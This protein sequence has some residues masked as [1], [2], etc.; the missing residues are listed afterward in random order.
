MIRMRL[1]LAGALALIVS[2]AQ[3]APLVA[4]CLQSGPTSVRC[5]PVN[6]GNPMPV[7]A[8]ITFPTIG[9]AVP[10]T[11]V[12][13]AL[14]VAGTLRGWNGLSLGSIFAGTVA[15]VDAS[16]N[17]IT[18]FGSSAA[19]AAT[20][21]AVPASANYIGINVGGTLTGWD[22]VLRAGSAIIGKVGIDQ[23]TPGTTNLVA[24]G[25][26]GT[27]TV[28]PGNTANTTP[29]LF[30]ISV[31]GNTAAVTT[32][33]ADAVSNTLSG[34]QVYARNQCFNGTTWDRCAQI[35]PGTAGTASANVLSIQGIAS[36]TPVQVSQATAA[37][38]NATVVGTG[39]FAVQ[40]APTPVTT[41]GLS[42]YF[43]QPAASDNHVNIKN[44]A[45]QVYKISVTNNSATAN[46]LRLYNAASGFNGCNSAT[47]LVYQMMIP[48]NSGYSDSWETGIAFSTGISICVTSGYATNDTTN[49]TASAMS[50]NVGYK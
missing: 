25:Q 16:G 8:T 6:S 34:L 21:G 11:G 41:G 5:D 4:P 49:A 46:Y 37:S 39:T 20:G 28:Q 33:G 32:A 35:S 23:T 26:N 24:A 31:G 40:A 36:M 3:A 7:T 44:G 13:N 45:G 48:A 18:S 50:V 15:I 47:N 2:S 38:L 43:V 14:N 19:V 1:L 29:W 9:S 30:S 42:V 17:Q 27:W 22:A 10:A 12:Y